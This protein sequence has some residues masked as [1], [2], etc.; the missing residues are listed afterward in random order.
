[1]LNS[2]EI[3]KALIDGLGWSLLHFVW[4]GAALG[5]CAA[6]LLIAM[7]RSSSLARYLVAV[8]TLALMGLAPVATTVWHMSQNAGIAPPVE[9]AS[10]SLVAEVP[11]ATSAIEA[12]SA[13]DQLPAAAE[14]PFDSP[15][16]ASANELVANNFPPAPTT[17]LEPAAEATLLE[18]A[19]SFCESHMTWIVNGWLAGVILLSLRMFVGWC[20]VQR[21]KRRGHQP[22]S[23]V[24]Q[25]MLTRLIE[26]LKVSRPVR[27]VESAL[28]EV[29]TV[30]GWLKPVILLPATA[31][32]GLSADQI[33]ALL[34]HELA[35]VRRNDYLINLLQ[36]VI[37]T[38]LFYHPAVWWLSR[39][40]RMEREHCCDD[41]AVQVCGDEV[42]Y[43]KALV[44]LEELRGPQIKLAMSADGGSLLGRIRRLVNPPRTVEDRSGWGVGA[45]AIVV[46][47]ALMIGLRSS[48]AETPD[49]SQTD[50]ALLAGDKSADDAP[51]PD[52]VAAF[53][54][55]D[56][57][58]KPESLGAGMLASKMAEAAAALNVG[59]MR[60]EFEKL[61]DQSW[62]SGKKDQPLVKTT[63]K[64]AW[65]NDGKQWRVDYDSELP[66]S[67]R[68]ETSPD[69]WTTGFDGERLY[70]FDRDGNS[71]V[72]GAPN[73]AARTYEP[74]NLFWNPTNGGLESVLGVLRKPDVKVEPAQLNGLDG[75][76][77]E[78]IVENDGTWRWSA[79]VCP[80][81]SYLV[82][83]LQQFLNDQLA[84]DC[85]LLDLVETRPGIWA[86]QTIQ[87]GSYT[88]SKEGQRGVAW[89]YD[90]KIKEL[91]IG[92][93]EASAWPTE[94]ERLAD[95]AHPTIKTP[96]GIAIDDLTRGVGYFNDPWW[97]DLEP[98]LKEK[99][100]WPKVSLLPLSNLRS[101][102]K[103]PRE[104]TPSAEQLEKLVQEFSILPWGKPTLQKL[105]PGQTPQFLEGH[106][107][108]FVFWAPWEQRSVKAL[109][110]AK[111]LHD[112]YAHFGLKIV[113]V[114]DAAKTEDGAAILKSLKLPFPSVVDAPPPDTNPWRKETLRELLGV[115]GMPTAVFVDHKRDQRKIHPIV[116]PN[117]FTE[118]IAELVKA[119]GATDVPILKLDEPLSDEIGQA[120]KAAWL[121]LAAKS[122]QKAEIKGRVVDGRHQ[123]LADAAI[124]LQPRLKLS[125]GGY[126]GVTVY[127]D[128][129]SVRT[130][131][132]D[133][134]GAFE[135]RSIPKASYE[136]RV[137]A[138]GYASRKFDLSAV[139]DQPTT[140]DVVLNQPDWI[141]GRVV[142][143]KGQPVKAAKV[144]ALLR[145]PDPNNLVA[146]VRSPGAMPKT[147]SQD[148]G[149]FRLENLEVGH[150]TYE[151][152][153]IGHE[154][155]VVKTVA[156]GKADLKVWL[157][158]YPEPLQRKVTLKA[159]RMPLHQA[160][161]SLCDA[162]KVEFQLDG[163]GLKTHGFTRNMP[164]TFEVTDL[165][166]G[167]ALEVLLSSF[168]QLGFVWEGK[169]VF[170]SVRDIAE[171]HRLPPLET[172]KGPPRERYTQLAYENA[173]KELEDAQRSNLKNPGSVA[174]L[175]LKKLQQ[176]VDATRAELD[177]VLHEASQVTGQP[178]T[179][180]F[181]KKSNDLLI[182]RVQTFLALNKTLLEIA[183][184]ANQKQPSSVPDAEVQRLRTQ[185]E[186]LEKDLARLKGQVAVDVRSL[187]KSLEVALKE[188][189][190]AQEA[191]Q[192]LPG[193]VPQSEVA[194]LERAASALARVKSV[195]LG[196]E[197]VTKELEDAQRANAQQLGTVPPLAIKQ[198]EQKL[199]AFRAEYETS[200]HEAAAFSGTPITPEYTQKLQELRANLLPTL[201]AWRKTQL[202]IA[203][204]ANQKQPDAV[205]MTELT[206]LKNDIKTFELN[207]ALM[208]EEAA[209]K[210]RSEDKVAAALKQLHVAQEANQR[211]P[212]SVTDSE[213]KTLELAVTTAVEQVEADVAQKEKSLPNGTATPVLQP[214]AER[215]A[216]QAGVVRG[217]IKIEG[218]IPKLPPIPNYDR[219]LAYPW[220]LKAPSDEMV[221]KFEADRAKNPAKYD[222]RKSRDESLTVGPRGELVDAIVYLPKAPPSWK[223]TAVP[224]EPATISAEADRFVPRLQFV[225]AGQQLMLSSKNNPAIDNF[226]SN[227]VKN[228]PF[229]MMVPKGESL[230]VP[231]ACLTQPENF[232]IEV[233]SDIQPGKRAWLLLLD[234][235]FA[236]VTDAEGRFEIKDL[237]PGKHQLRVW[238]ERSGYLN[239]SVEV[240]VKAEQPAEPLSLN[241]PFEKLMPHRDDFMKDALGRPELSLLATWS[242]VSNEFTVEAGVLTRAKIILQLRNST[243]RP[244][245][246]TLPGGDWKQ[247]REVK[248]R[249]LKVTLE[250]AA[251]AK[252]TELA[253][254]A[255]ETI[256]LP[257]C[258][259]PLDLTGLDAG[260][261]SVQL[262]T[263]LH[264]ATCYLTMW[265]DAGQKGAAV[266]RLAAP[267]Q[268]IVRVAD[269]EA[270]AKHQQ[271]WKQKV[272]DIA[273]LVTQRDQLA[274][275]GKVNDQLESQLA[276]ERVR[277]AQIKLWLAEEKNLSLS[278]S[279]T[280]E[281][282]D[283]LKRET[284][285]RW[286]QPVDGIQIGLERVS[287][288]DTATPG[289]PV[290]FRHRARN[291]TNQV[292]HRTLKF[293]ASGDPQVKIHAGDRITLRHLGAATAMAEIELPPGADLP[294]AG[295]E[296]TLKTDGLLPGRYQ[297][298]SYDQFAW[299]DAAQPERQRTAAAP[300][301]TQMPSDL[302]LGFDVVADQL[303]AE[304]ASPQPVVLQGSADTRWGVP[305]QGL[306]AG[307]RYTRPLARPKELGDATNWE[308]KLN[309]VVKA[310]YLIRNVLTEPASVTY[311]VVGEKKPVALLPTAHS[312]VS[313]DDNGP[314]Q[315]RRLKG[316][317]AW[318][319]GHEPTKERRTQRLEPGEVIV[320]ATADFQLIEQ[321]K[322]RTNAEW[323]KLPRVDSILVNDGGKYRFATSL[324]VSKTPDISLDL[325]SGSLPLFVQSETAEPDNALE[326]IPAGI[327]RVSVRYEMPGGPAQAEVVFKPLRGNGQPI[328]KTVRQAETI[329]AFELPAGH[330]EVV[331]R[332]TLN[333][334]SFEKSIDCNRQAIAVKPQSVANVEFVRKAE[335]VT[336]VKGQWAKLSD[337]GVTGAF[338]SVHPFDTKIL[339]TGDPDSAYDFDA[340][341]EIIAAG[342]CG[343][344][345]RFL[346]ESLPA[347]RYAVVLRAFRASSQPAGRVTV[348]YVVG[349]E[350]VSVIRPDFL[351]YYPNEFGVRTRWN[352]PLWLPTPVK[353]KVDERVQ[354]APEAAKPADAIARAVA[355]L[356][357]QQEAD[358]SWK[359][360]ET[361][362]NG[363]TALSTVALL[364]S[365]VKADEAE[366]Q[367]ALVRLRKVE[368]SQTYTVALQTIAFCLASPQDHADLIRRNVAWLEQAQVAAGPSTGGWSY[369]QQ[370]GGRG[371]GSCTRFAVLGLHAAKE[372]GFDVKQQ[373]WQRLSEYWMKNRTPTG[374][375]AY[376][377]GAP[378]TI[379]MTLAGVAGLA[380][381]HRYLPNDDDA[382]AREAAMQA[383]AKY[384]EKVISEWK[385][386]STPLYA[387][388]C[389]ERA[390]HVSGLEKF[391]EVDWQAAS[392]PKLLKLQ[393]PNGSWRGNEAIENDIVATSLGLLTLTG[394]SDKVRVVAVAP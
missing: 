269:P 267:E 212:G 336:P 94:A 28:V 31:L 157:D 297:V 262:Q 190:V 351:S 211:L 123:P 378:P 224:K 186:Q 143:D 369:G 7:R 138:A 240:T 171:K 380:T 9:T 313:Y 320:V 355:Y 388:H 219:S 333:T 225:R 266:A 105:K 249:E 213:I 309:D 151:V 304:A 241:Y 141:G 185:I 384:L 112:E 392:V 98:I 16:L 71:L 334:G 340:Q 42:S 189:Q 183:I 104:T 1:M 65:R 194:K 345:G 50:S 136:V 81:R 377:Q 264:K 84:W 128:H 254:P 381:A 348:P 6:A 327:G 344:D 349:V 139:A 376:S 56:T 287:L 140:L 148:D 64:I 133:T 379:T 60:V 383:P 13:V 317:V 394:Q 318:S 92:P 263:P 32:T 79:F 217:Q 208:N 328:V 35:H 18:S 346:L 14:L 360:P 91:K 230:A 283:A 292:L 315:N 101:N 201:L 354:A 135:F 306:Q 324:A 235:P 302:S 129:K 48:P 268:K 265:I 195:Q 202:E 49:V 220:R 89:Q 179:P 147:V 323:A 280:P 274:Q 93:A 172:V 296:F 293:A 120:A 386:T 175:P 218:R 363:V 187:E 368:P 126:G 11:D 164:A 75:Y 163:E 36:T 176:T 113:A 156:L 200:L 285:V 259:V 184:D 385:P 275:D 55:K 106:V 337:A 282:L 169:R 45:I 196:L 153:A 167:D 252:P 197:R 25:A 316:G 134:Q 96:F 170:V 46:L 130:L 322:E 227:P 237:P 12:A 97:S 272:A 68:P 314:L 288:N 173:T 286:A 374:L 276:M 17:S 366:I 332:L 365:G 38:L 233:R 258:D 181:S 119:A 144:E 234:H 243:D 364:Q 228:N 20:R 203:V 90:F 47:A 326:A 193:T 115:R 33:E 54:E 122:P 72:I 251:D 308:W 210:L 57:A 180:E 298:E 30:I 23:D 207:I 19:R 299:S 245:T 121:D 261:W 305:V 102:I 290:E 353:A 85:K 339:N 59:R 248:V 2:I 117:K 69:H 149:G 63:G 10:K 161:Q 341:R 347:G 40:I 273:K 67:G 289:R 78:R 239:K 21:L 270:A 221:A 310:E 80:S 15:A 231:A 137:K 160:L 118:Q 4:Q 166:L 229:N 295:S 359:G 291:V 300:G 198:L 350:V 51:E 294:I 43:A 86:P 214:S 3:P 27:L 236:A 127:P 391:G 124:E 301:W 372:A 154:R 66:N 150:Y 277:L 244:V 73:A 279:T 246:I 34:A 204:E 39:R 145:H 247:R 331:R 188:F 168:E 162:A 61:T 325:R 77:V 103:E 205:P 125:R 361:F 182:K 199:D 44:A 342:T 191:N 107:F 100:D 116:D 393:H 362:E 352:A 99:H 238:H 209:T 192:R 338:I 242:D 222:P 278:N 131:K 142:N 114:Q 367:K 329:A 87:R 111:R 146:T 52:Q 255:F 389:L 22:A 281:T 390:G 284:L 371:D 321:P 58:K 152:D 110:A 223:P 382:K 132:T 76:R 62:I 37:E 155:R 8:A 319:E 232:P 29:P 53:A 24:L 303:A 307:L 83:E 216:A 256:Q 178:I 387:Y 335:S 74:S 206:L 165:P 226:H 177:L 158:E 370:H 95:F 356:K 41:L 271:A 109:V 26:R 311:S 5:A 82:T 70:D 253:I 260:Y 159:Q 357:D 373:T 330:Y 88:W 343:A 257:L 250:P 215:T 108:L 174:P 375:W 312:V 358:G